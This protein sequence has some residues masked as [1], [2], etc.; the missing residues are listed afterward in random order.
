MRRR[1][2]A[3]A[4]VGLCCTAPRASGETLAGALARAY[5]TNPT[6]NAQRAAQRANDENVPHAQAQFRPHVRS[7]SYIGVERRRTI[8][9]STEIPNYDYLHP[10]IL[11]SIQNNRSLPRGEALS[12]EQPLF[13]GFRTKNATLAAETGVHAGRERLRLVEQRVLFEAT[14]AYMNVLRD[15]AALRLQQNNVAL[16]QEQLRQTKERYAAG[17]ITPTDIA[18]A[19]SRLAAGRSRAAA[20]RAD[21]EASLGNYRRLMGAEP[22]QLAPGAAVDRLLP[23]NREAAERIALAEH[24]VVRA[25]QHDAD[26]AD[27]DIKVIESDFMPSLSMV[28]QVYT[29]SDI[30]G[31]GN[32]AVGAQVLGK[33]SVPLYSGGETSARMRQAKEVAGQ[34]KL[35]IDV[36]RAELLALTRANWGALEAAKAQLAA[37]SAQIEAAE[38]ALTGVREE[39]KAG[40]RTTLDILNAQQEL[41]GARIGLVF[42][43]RDRVV[44][45]YA[46]LAAIGRL[47]A[48]TLGLTVA[49]YDPAAHF[50]RVKNSWGD[51]PLL[52]N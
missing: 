8:G 9:I 21:L 30:Q 47:S 41:L 24:P 45:S 32:R 23:K 52:G 39:A 44:A 25:A 28:G 34:R 26:A 49:S 12:V 3:V 42:A 20:A 10:D 33:L 7:D 15:T 1:L 4:L 16:L 46:A 50:E 43:Q 6:I 48:Q 36:A 11:I 51:A 31:R 18:Q 27:L 19:E 14:A 2:V 13:D 37:A 5:E 38:R 17:E 35:D 29:Q 22:K 40:K